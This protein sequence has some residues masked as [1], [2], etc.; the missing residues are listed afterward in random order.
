MIT[1]ADF[2][3]WLEV[4]NVPHGCGG[5]GGVTQQEV[6]RFAFNYSLTAGVSDAFI[7][8]LDPAVTTLTDGL[9]VSMSSGALENTTTSPTLQVNALT[10]V[11]ITLW[12][13]LS[14]YPGDIQANSVY[15]FL[16]NLAD[17]VFQLINPS[18][19][20]ANTSLAQSGFYNAA[21]DSGAADAY[22]VTLNPP[23]QGSFGEGFPL[24]LGIGAGNTNTGA[25]TIDVNGS[26]ESIYLNDGSE[27][28]AGSLVENQTY[29]L[30]YSTGV[31]GWVVVNETSTSTSAGGTSGQIQ[32]N[33]GGILAGD[34]ALTDGAGNWSN[35]KSIQMETLEAQPLFYQDSY[36]NGSTGYENIYNMRKS[37]G[38]T[39][40]AQVAVGSADTI[41]AHQFYGSDG[42]GFINAASITATVDGTVSAGVVP[43]KLSL[44]TANVTTGTLTTALTINSS[45]VVSLAKALP[46]NSGGTGL[47][48]TTAN[49]LLYSSATS[50]I[51][52]LATANNGLLVT[53]AAGVPSIGN[54]IGASI[55]VTGT[56]TGTGTTLNTPSFNVPNG[57]KIK[58]ASDNIYNAYNLVK[59]V[60][61]NATTT[62]L[63][64]TVP[65]QGCFF[66]IECFISNSRAITSGAGTSQIQKKYFSIARATDSDV[67]LDSQTGPDFVSVT[68]TAG[69]GFNANSG[70]TSIVRNGAE[71]ST[72]T[73]VVN[74][75]I[76]PVCSGPATGQAI[77][78]MTILAHANNSFGFAIT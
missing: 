13:G 46:V 52:G 78:Y 30:L 27:L 11:P 60:S 45:Q 22:V 66:A 29:M 3:K 40:G 23:P 56:V 1:A 8:T 9:I 72:S 67:V 64:V 34:A 74:L 51:A 28:P 18:I 65:N 37:R 6:Q 19:S 2:L 58:L 59:T 26:V 68:T 14:L 73:Q 41:G 61:G 38:A 7:V 63:Q 76:N 12:A 55:S 69:G 62:F 53:S 24:Y 36:S 71:S 15:L 49:Q 5:S 17:N 48:S 16:Y 47:S 43:G 25:S 21:V 75:T 54:T 20:T 31:G 39:I 32:W 77:I 35:V 33:N 57:G 42:T 44:R 10:P 50:T 4:Y 70:A